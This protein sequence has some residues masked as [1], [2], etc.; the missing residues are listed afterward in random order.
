MAA[1]WVE[2]V[3]LVA[4]TLG[5]IAWF[6]QIRE[7]WVHR[8]HEGISLPTFGLI[9]VALALW[10]V[11]GLLIDSKAILVAN[12]AALVVI[13]VVIIGVVRLRRQ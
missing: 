3:G 4:G 2:A 13:L 11:Y 12:I 7:V 10:L 8:R 6:P 5:I 9:T 1:W